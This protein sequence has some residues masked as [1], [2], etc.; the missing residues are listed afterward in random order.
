MAKYKAN[1]E[2]A[3]QV[4]QVKKIKRASSKCSFL[5][6]EYKENLANYHNSHILKQIS[7]M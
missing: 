3:A 7:N 4:M 1:N 5:R 2:S 6:G